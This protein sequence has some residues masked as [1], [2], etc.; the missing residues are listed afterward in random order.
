MIIINWGAQDKAQL[1]GKGDSLGIMQEIKIW[2][3]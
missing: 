1:D 2:P 3:Y